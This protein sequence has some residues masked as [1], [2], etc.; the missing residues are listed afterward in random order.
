MRI[1]V[2]IDGFN[3]YYRCLKGTPYK[4]LDI[5]R[6][7]QT[8]LSNEGRVDA[9][10]YFTAKV[11]STPNDPD[12]SIRQQKYLDAIAAQIPCLQIHYGT[13]KLRRSTGKLIRP[14]LQGVRT[15]EIEKY[16]EKGSDVNLAVQM[17]NDAWSDKFDVAA[18]ISND[19][20]LEEP[21][22]LIKAQFPSKKI[23][24]LSPD[25]AQISYSLKQH[26]DKIW[27]IRKGLLK[28]SQ[29]PDSIP[30]TNITKPP[31]W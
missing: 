4:W 8:L 24:L 16:E 18:L 30:G 31:T 5:C 2:Y 1:S 19:S 27:K 26:A 28:I 9:I 20:D 11:S 25:G 7:S 15:V 13:F 22:K 14:S 10:K 29:M 3:L 12:Q 6:M 23:Y 21:L 17:L